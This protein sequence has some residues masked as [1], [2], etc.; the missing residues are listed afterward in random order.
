MNLDEIP[1]AT[2]AHDE[3]AK[4]PVSTKTRVKVYTYSLPVRLVMAIRRTKPDV[5]I[6][7]LDQ[8]IR[9]IAQRTPP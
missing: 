4:V 9:N 5:G 3:P 6:E 8:I 1:I 2:V 7:E